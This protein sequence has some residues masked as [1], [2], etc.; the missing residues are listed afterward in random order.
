MSIACPCCG[1]DTL[2]RRANYE[3]CAICCWED[4]PASDRERRATSNRITLRQAQQNFVAFGACEEEYHA[5]ARQSTADD[6][7]LPNWQPLEASLRQQQHALL[8]RFVHHRH[9][10]LEEVVR[11]VH[12]GLLHAIAEADY[13][14]NVAEHLTVL[15]QIHSGTIPLPIQW[16]QREVLE[17][18]RWSQPDGP[19]GRWDGKD[20]GRDGHLQRLFACTALLQIGAEPENRQRLLGRDK[21]TIIQLIGSIVAL[22]LPLHRPA[23]RLLSQRV[24]ALDLGDQELPFFAMG[25]LLLA[26]MLPDGEPAHLRELAIWLLAEEARIRDECIVDGERPTDQWLLGLAT[27]NTYHD[28]W[29]STT[30]NLLRTAIPTLPSTVTT[31]LQTMIERMGA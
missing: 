30:I 21:D 26:T 2:T 14:M 13:G 6:A 20:A 24:L 8:D 1:Y 10:L 17:L 23:L 29:Q 11:F 25:I 28:E 4:L 22:D 15:R 19:N 3:I 12:D 31:M 18:V 9:G 27:Y 7:R 5:L 16:E